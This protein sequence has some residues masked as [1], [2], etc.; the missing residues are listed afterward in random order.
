MLPP[1][2]IPGRTFWTYMLLYAISR[3]II[4]IYRGDERGMLAGV[5]TSQFVAILLLQSGV[6]ARAIPHSLA[7]PKSGR[8]RRAASIR[9]CVPST[10]SAAWTS[11]R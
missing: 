5:S 6:R 11:P 1:P 4:E 3:F 9:R 7:T 2:L 10:P 8:C